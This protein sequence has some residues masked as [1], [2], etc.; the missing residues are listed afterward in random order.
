[1][2][3]SDLGSVPAKKEL[4]AAPTRCLNAPRGPLQ[5]LDR[6]IE[7]GHANLSGDP[8]TAYGRKTFRKTDGQGHSRADRACSTGRRGWRTTGSSS[9]AWARTA[10][11]RIRILRRPG[12]SPAGR[13][14]SSRDW[15][16][17][18]TVVPRRVGSYCMAILSVWTKYAGSPKPCLWT[19]R[20][21]TLNRSLP[22]HGW[23]CS[24]TTGGRGGR[25]AKRGTGMAM[26]RLPVPPTW[27]R[28]WVEYRSLVA[29]AESDESIELMFPTQAPEIET[30]DPVRMLADAMSGLGVVRKPSL[31]TGG[32]IRDTVSGCGEKRFGADGRRLW[33]RP[34]KTSPRL[35]GIFPARCDRPRFWMTVART[36]T[37]DH[38]RH[39]LSKRQ[40]RKPRDAQDRL[41]SWSSYQRARK[42]FRLQAM[43]SSGVGLF[44]TSMACRRFGTV[45][46][47]LRVGVATFTRADGWPSTPG[48]Q[49]AR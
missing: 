39:A 29:E 19:A 41:L 13:P 48:A 6:A 16:E 21:Q 46:E 25:H 31:E 23:R 30:L 20:G 9:V 27:R 38:S 14:R 10:A 5:R 28:W 35:C 40:P 36:K 34:R 8:Q 37:T 3:R 45:R 1:M 15:R 24:C 4:P 49:R 33:R 18:E 2:D 22:R 11:A 42:G 44:W 43:L 12:V 26:V 7:T 47:G 32:D 17:K